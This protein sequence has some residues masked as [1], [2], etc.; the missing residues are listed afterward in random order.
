M[1]PLY[2]FPETVETYFWYDG[3]VLFSARVL[4]QLRLITLQDMTDTDFVYIVSSPLDEQLTAMKENR[5]PLRDAMSASPYFKMTVPY[6]AAIANQPDV[7]VVA[8]IE[9]ID[10]WPEGSLADPGIYLSLET[11]PLPQR[12]GAIA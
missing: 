5:L 8:T 2:S 10:A 9:P 3:P 12:S 6:G 4:G 11:D 7:A 1:T